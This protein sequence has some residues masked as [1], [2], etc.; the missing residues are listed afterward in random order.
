MSARD[1]HDLIDKVR[2]PQIGGLIREVV[3]KLEADSAHLRSEN[4]RLQ[5]ENETHR[6][7]YVRLDAA[8]TASAAAYRRQL[9]L[10][11]A[12]DRDDVIRLEAIVDKIPHTKD[13]VPVLPGMSLWQKKY[14]EVQRIEVISLDDLESDWPATVRMEFD[15]HPGESSTYRWHV[16]GCYSTKE[17]A[18]A[19]CP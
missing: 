2:V 12:P 8:L 14:N 1:L 17:A 13:G 7:E 3:R 15:S 11:Q 6:T 5:R 16:Q 18:L 10:R 19:G 4:G 9:R